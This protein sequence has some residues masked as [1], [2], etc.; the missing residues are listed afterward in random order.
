MLAKMYVSTVHMYQHTERT[1]G[2]GIGMYVNMYVH[3]HSNMYVP[4]YHTM[5][6]F[7]VTYISIIRLYTIYVFY[8]QYSY[9]HVSLFRAFSAFS[10]PFP[11]QLLAIYSNCVFF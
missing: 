1:I 8:I 3:T 9:I 5:Y 11:V 2:I 10:E 7:Q 6:K 4:Y